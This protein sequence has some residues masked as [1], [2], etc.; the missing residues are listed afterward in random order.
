MNGLS[1]S[2]VR[3]VGDRVIGHCTSRMTHHLK[4]SA[5]DAR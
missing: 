5:M 4:C 3:L 2:I 1:G